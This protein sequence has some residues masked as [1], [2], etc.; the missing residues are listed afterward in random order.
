MEGWEGRE[1][2]REGDGASNNGARL[3]KMFFATGLI[4]IILIMLVC[5]KQGEILCNI[6]KLTEYYWHIRI[7]NHNSSKRMTT[8]NLVA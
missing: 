7:H 3:G 6:T 1:V 2:G 5:A 8:N 4:E